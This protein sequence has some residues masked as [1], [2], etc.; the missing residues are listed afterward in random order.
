MNSKMR[1]KRILGG[2]VKNFLGKA[3]DFLKKTKLLSTVG[4][5]LN[6]T[7]VPMPYRGLTQKVVDFGK[8]AG[9]GRKKIKYTRN[10]VKAGRIAV[11]NRSM[12][13]QGL[14]LAGSG[15]RPNRLPHRLPSYF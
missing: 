2:S 5:V 6:N 10:K 11:I 14:R 3:N 7:I 1:H 15:T 12:L 13:G 8:S 9:Y 4:N